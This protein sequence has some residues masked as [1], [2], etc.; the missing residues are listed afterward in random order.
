MSAERIR[1]QV[2]DDTSGQGKGTELPDELKGLNWGWGLFN[3]TTIALL[4][5]LPFVNPVMAQEKLRRHLDV[6]LVQVGGTGEFHFRTQ[7]QRDA[8]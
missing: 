2:Q 4:M 5:L 3:K 8:P 7:G 1:S 6:P